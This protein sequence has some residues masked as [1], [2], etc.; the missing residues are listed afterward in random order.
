[1]HND[2]ISEIINP[3]TSKLSIEQ[4]IGYSLYL[5]TSYLFGKNM[6]NIPASIWKMVVAV[7][8]QTTEEHENLKTKSLGSNNLNIATYRHPKQSLKLVLR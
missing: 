4:I 2:Y 3:F 7:P 5:I 8:H 1:M 6:Y